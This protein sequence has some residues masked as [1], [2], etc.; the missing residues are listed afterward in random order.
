MLLAVGFVIIALVGAVYVLAV[1]TP[2]RDRTLHSKERAL[3]TARE[4]AD[5]GE[6]YGTLEALQAARPEAAAALLR[7][8]HREDGPPIG[9]VQTF[10]HAPFDHATSIDYQ[11]TSID[12]Q[13][14]RVATPSESSTPDDD[15]AERA[16]QQSAEGAE[17]SLSG[18]SGGGE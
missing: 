5:T 6:V 9:E 8:H 17:P 1:L 11:S 13:S 7:D 15:G 2:R 12:Y 18:Q 4:C 16:P 14:I 10:D 3:R